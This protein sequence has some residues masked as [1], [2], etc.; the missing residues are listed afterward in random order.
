MIKNG[1]YAEPQERTAGC[2]NWHI[3]CNLMVFLFISTD[4]TP[5]GDRKYNYF[6]DT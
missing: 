4:Y 6:L 2:R 1:I 3:D 5:E